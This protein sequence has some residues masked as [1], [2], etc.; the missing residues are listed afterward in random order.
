MKNKS[1]WLQSG[2]ILAAI[3][4]FFLPIFIKNQGILIYYGDSFEE[5]YQFY[6][7]GWEKVHALDFSQFDWSIGLGGNWFAYS[8][9]YLL[10]P[11]FWLTVPFPKSWLPYEMTALNILKLLLT[12]QFTYLWI[13]KITRNELTRFVCGAMVAFSGWVFFYNHYTNFLDAYLM[14]PLILYFAE[15]YLQSGKFKGFVLSMCSLTLQTYYFAYMFMPFG[16]LYGLFRYLMMHEKIN[17]KDLLIT[18]LKYFGLLMLGIGMAACILL[19]TANTL[20]GNPRMEETYGFF[21]TIGKFDVFKIITSLFTPVFSRLNP[22]Y[23][24][25]V[26]KIGDL[27]WGYGCSLFSLVL[28]PAL[29]LQLFGMLKKREIRWMLVFYLLLGVFV[30]FPTSWLILQGTIDTRWFYM[31]V[32]LNALSSCFVLDAYQRN[33]IPKKYLMISIA[34]TLA[35][36]VGLF[37][38]SYIKRLNTYDMLKQ[39]LVVLFVE[40]IILVVYFL[41]VWKNRKV[42]LVVGVVCEIL[43]SGLTHMVYN[44]PREYPLF[45]RGDGYAVAGGRT[46]AWRTARTLEYHPRRNDN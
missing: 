18:A 32:L 13:S 30:L 10:S 35:A 26:D 12:F 31:I 16:C 46:A 36:I 34:I 8:D 22:D 19:P 9:V 38:I 39:L 2:L 45:G 1:F 11:Y 23:F 25:S 43:L 33:E 27:G 42:L 3:L 4:I 6:L 14:F 24:I 7:G 20:F 15:C 40:C 5:F 21:D 44:P 28:F 17:I 37:G 29:F 41:G